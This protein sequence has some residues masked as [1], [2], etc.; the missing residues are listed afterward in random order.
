MP[1]R[2]DNNDHVQF[3]GLHRVLILLFRYYRSQRRVAN[4]SPLGRRSR[5]VPD[6]RLGGSRHQRPG[7]HGHVLPPHNSKNARHRHCGERDFLS[8]ELRS[9]G[10]RGLSAQS[11]DILCHQQGTETAATGC[12]AGVS[13]VPSEQQGPKYCPKARL[14]SPAARL[15]S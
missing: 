8:A 10:A 4:G 1:Q 12:I 2:R 7:I 11:I 14:V 3:C 15:A 13:Q 6:C 9:C 5:S